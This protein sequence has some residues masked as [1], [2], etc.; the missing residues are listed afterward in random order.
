VGSELFLKFPKGETLLN[1][2]EREGE[3]I[4]LRVPL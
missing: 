4:D 2:T 3:K 1:K